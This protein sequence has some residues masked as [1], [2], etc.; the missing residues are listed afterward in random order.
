[1]VAVAPSALYTDAEVRALAMVKA[2]K[3]RKDI[4]PPPPDDWQ[5]WLGAVFGDS[6][7][8][9]FASYQERFWEWV[10]EIEAGEPLHPFVAIWPRTYAKSTS[11]EMACAAVAAR[12]TRKYVMYV[13]GT[14]S[15]ADDHVKNVSKL[16]QSS[17]FIKHYPK[18]G[19]VKKTPQGVN[20]AWRRDRISTDSDFVVDAIGLDTAARGIKWENIRPDL[21][22]VDD[23]DDPLDSP[24]MVQKKITMLAKGLIPSGAPN[25]IVVVVQNLIHEDG[26]VARL[27]DGRADFLANREVS[28]PHP[29]IDSAAYEQDEKGRWRITA[30]TTSWPVRD[31]TSL[32]NILDKIGISAFRAELQHEVNHHE[33]GMFSK[34]IFRHC[35]LSEVPDLSRIVVWV[36]P[37]VT[38]TDQSDAHGIQ[39][40]GLAANDDIYRLWS[41]E[42]RASPEQAIKMAILKA[43]D[44]HAESV[45]VETDQGGNT[46]QSVY[47]RVWEALIASGEILAD[48]PMP[49]F[50][51][52]KAGAG[53][54]PKAHRASQMLAAYERGE[55]VHVIYPGANIHETLE[56]GL[57]RY[58][59]RKPF[60]LV[61]AAY[62]SYLDL[63]TQSGG[64][65]IL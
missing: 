16:L 14:Q 46:W 1:M 55:F 23:I 41:W 37:A 17:E 63:R 4:L 12:G 21:L 33:G 59:I 19:A 58:L 42:E 38:D 36:D 2:R 44:L 11:V 48:T 7:Q 61:D 20:D 64:V 51:Q 25:S 15:Q 56:R 27:A 49:H 62:W 40:D 39:A 18:V 8:T 47:D 22:I 50:K 54:G 5:G 24:G 34:I 60:D 32:Q 52:A 45:G 35:P 43:V 28:G 30:G 29:A 31:L 6:I 10:W 3:Y 26:I 9:P 65:R 53:H 13:C 57:K